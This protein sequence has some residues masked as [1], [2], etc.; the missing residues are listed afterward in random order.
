SRKIPVIFDEIIFD[1]TFSEDKKVFSFEGIVPLS[2][3]LATEEVELNFRITKT[4]HAYFL[5]LIHGEHLEWDHVSSL[6]NISCQFMLLLY[7]NFFSVLYIFHHQATP[8]LR[9][10]SICAHEICVGYVM[11]ASFS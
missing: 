6:N 2:A 7:N 5:F 11:G 4:M 1:N 9:T 3:T 8:H 10:T